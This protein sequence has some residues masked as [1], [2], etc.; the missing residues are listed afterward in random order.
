MSFLRSPSVLV[1]KDSS[2]PPSL[3]SSPSPLSV[4][5]PENDTQLFLV[6]FCLTV[7]QDVAVAVAFGM[8]IAL[9]VFVQVCGR[10]SARST[11]RSATAHMLATL[12]AEALYPPAC[13]PLIFLENFPFAHRNLTLC[14]Q[15]GAI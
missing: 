7:L 8:A 6:A 9:A 3:A 12:P 1:G 5:G 13:L 10:R 2:I 4:A 11:V 14:T 15:S